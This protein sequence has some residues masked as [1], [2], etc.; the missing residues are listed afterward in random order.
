MIHILGILIRKIVNRDIWVK[1]KHWAIVH[2]WLIFS[3]GKSFD[4]SDDS[5]GPREG[6]PGMPNMVASRM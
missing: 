6:S 1:L 4:F 3:G 2:V 5:L